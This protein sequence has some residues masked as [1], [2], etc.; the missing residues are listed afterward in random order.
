MNVTVL[1]YLK[2]LQ[3]NT[4]DTLLK[5][6]HFEIREPRAVGLRFRTVKPV[7]Q[8]PTGSVRLGYYISTR[9]NGVDQPHWPKDLIQEI[10]T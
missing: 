5:L 3:Q 1:A 9:R 8:F 10:V 4:R 7:I 6:A 2:I